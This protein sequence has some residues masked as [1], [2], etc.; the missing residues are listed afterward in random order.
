MFEEQLLDP[1]RHARQAFRSGIPEL[2]DYL[3]RFAA[4]QSKKGLAVVRV[5]V[6][7]EAPDTILGYYTLSA[8]QIDVLQLDEQIRQKLP[9]YPLPCFRLGRLAVHVDH[10][11]CGLGRLLIGCAVRR[12]LEARKQVAAHALI[13]DAKSEKGKA[14]YTHYGF[15]SCRDQ[16][17]CLYL[18]LGK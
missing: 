12:C 17:L 16:P 6:K 18:P 9:R 10:Q 2:D 14:F 1:S 4:Q 15:I 7:P 3:C 11:G 8:A 5:L 13:V